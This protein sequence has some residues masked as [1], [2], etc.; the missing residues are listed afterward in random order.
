MTTSRLRVSGFLWS[1][2]GVLHRNAVATHQE[3]ATTTSQCTAMA[4]NAA[5]AT[6][7]FLHKGAKQGGK[8]TSSK[9]WEISI[10]RYFGKKSWAYPH[11]CLL[12]VL[13]IPQAWPATE[14][15]RTCSLHVWQESFPLPQEEG[16]AF[17][18][19]EKNPSH[20]IPHTQQLERESKIQLHH[21]EYGILFT[22]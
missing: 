5:L 19:D 7:R 13:L 12:N 10:V 21:G 22:R 1:R 9:G 11:H 15:Q 4:A 18:F 20:C 3:A 14:A 2:V 16:A 17:E 6:D 8:K